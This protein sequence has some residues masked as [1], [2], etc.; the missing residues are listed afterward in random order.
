[1]DFPESQKSSIANSSTLKKVMSKDAASLIAEIDNLRTKIDAAKVFL[2]E[3]ENIDPGVINV[4]EAEISRCQ[5]RIYFLE[6]EV[7]K[8]DRDSGLKKNQKNNQQD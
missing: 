4:T 6:R 7:E 8:F 5:E 2:A 1:M 3:N